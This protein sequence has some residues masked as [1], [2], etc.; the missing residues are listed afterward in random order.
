MS[1]NID[2]RSFEAHPKSNLEKTT[3]T[4]HSS[5]SITDPLDVKSFKSR[6][7]GIDSQLE[8]QRRKARNEKMAQELQKIKDKRFM[9]NANN[10]AATSRQS[11]PGA[12]SAPKRNSVFAPTSS[13][14]SK[15]FGQ[16]KLPATQT[17]QPKFRQSMTFGKPV[18]GQAAGSL[19]K[20]RRLGSFVSNNSNNGSFVSP[21]KQTAAQ[22]ILATEKSQKAVVDIL[23]KKKTVNRASTI[24]LNDQYGSFQ[25]DNKSFVKTLLK[26]VKTFESSSSSNTSIIEKADSDGKEDAN[27]PDVESCDSD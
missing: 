17:S 13:S 14:K 9:V 25:D 22:K 8:K 16:S 1:W 23:S 15:Q 2:E 4:G 10:Y 5:N 6:D 24:S 11:M 19:G 27:E 18:G 26:G 3:K 12:S 7:S 20:T 21:E